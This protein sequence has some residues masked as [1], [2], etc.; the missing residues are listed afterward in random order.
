MSFEGTNCPCG[1][2]KERETLLCRACDSHLEGTFEMRIYR[3]KDNE[4]GERRCAAIR[5]LAMARRRKRGAL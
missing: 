5:L 2:R 1:D 3:A 4:R